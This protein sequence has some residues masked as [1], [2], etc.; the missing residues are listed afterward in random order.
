MKHYKL[1]PAFL[2]T[3]IMLLSACNK[4]MNDYFYKTDNLAIAL[5]GYNGSTEALEIRLDTSRYPHE[6]AASNP[7]Q[8]SSAYTFYD[9]QKN[10]VRLSVT[11][12][13]SG[14]LVLEKELK[15]EDGPAQVNFLYM[16][17]KVSAWPDKPVTEPEKIKI[18]YMFIPQITNYSEPVDICFGKYF[19]TPQVFEEIT[20]IKSLK[21]YEFSEP[22]VFP[23]FSTARQEYNGV[24]TTVSFVVRIFKAG[25]NIPYIDGTEYTWHPINSTAPK[26]PAG[27]A[28]SKMYIFNEQLSGNIMRFYTR[29]DQ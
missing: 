17:G 26:P 19:A 29:V 27:T 14:K 16:D 9:N 10:S 8:L 7:F 12:K 23:T 25:T 4:G 5:K 24:M 6:L 20:R 1:I 21:P 15:K 13:S 28:S 3:A 11:E 2:S 22:A 18:M